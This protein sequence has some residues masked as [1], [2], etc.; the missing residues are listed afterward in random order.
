MRLADRVNA[1]QEE[2]KDD[3]GADAKAETDAPKKKKTGFFA[4]LVKTFET[5]PSSAD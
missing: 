1:L 4:S 3:T 5:Q 2:S